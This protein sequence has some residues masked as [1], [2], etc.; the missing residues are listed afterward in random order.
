MKAYIVYEANTWAGSHRVEIPEGTSPAQALALAKMIHKGC[1]T[2]TK[3][4]WRAYE[5]RFCVAETTSFSLAKNTVFQGQMI[6]LKP[7]T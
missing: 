5:G 6:Q 1:R 3:I 4:G 2:L 7:A